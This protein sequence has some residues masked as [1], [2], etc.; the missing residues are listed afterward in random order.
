MEKVT[1]F[2]VCPFKSGTISNVGISKLKNSEGEKFL[3][4]KIVGGYCRISGDA[5]KAREC[6]RTEKVATEYGYHLSAPCLRLHLA[7][8]GIQ[9]E[10]SRM[11]TNTHS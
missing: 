4:E 3:F 9:S 10:W 6:V 2:N 7:Y 1:S 8:K 5:A 11:N